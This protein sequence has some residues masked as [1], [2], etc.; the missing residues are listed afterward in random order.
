MMN[1]HIVSYWVFIVSQIFY[2]VTFLG[3]GTNESTSALSICITL[4][5]VSS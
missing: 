3:V 2:F 1:A 4:T 5:A